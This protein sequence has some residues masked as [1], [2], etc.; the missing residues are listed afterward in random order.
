MRYIDALTWSRVSGCR[1]K[2]LSYLAV[3][4]CL[5]GLAFAIL[6]FTLN[7]GAVVNRVG[8]L[9]GLLHAWWTFCLVFVY[10][11]PDMS[12]A[13]LFDRLSYV[14]VLGLNPALAWFFLR[15][16]GVSNRAT[17]AVVVTAS[18][19]AALVAYGYLTGG[20][21][22]AAFAPGPWGNVGIPASDQTWATVSD[23]AFLGLDA[24]SFGILVQ[25]S[26]KAGSWRQKRLIHIVLAGMGFAVAAYLVLDAL[27]RAW[28]MPSLIFLPS[29]LLVAFNFYAI[30]EYRF[31]MPEHPWLEG[32]LAEAMNR[33][34]LLLDKAGLIVGVNLA[35]RQRLAPTQNPVG[36]GIAS[37]AT[38]PEAFPGLWSTIQGG[39]PGAEGHLET[40]YGRFHLSGHYDRFGDFVGVVALSAD[41]PGVSDELKGLSDREAEVLKLLVTGVG[42]QA[43]ADRLFVSPGTVKS[44][45]HSIL[46]KTGVRKRQDL[47]QRFGRMF[48]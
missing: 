37:W 45:V 6:V 28:A 34:A 21:P 25:K 7:P 18:A 42:N 4:A 8:A 32:H 30:Y 14:A 44:H 5:E 9:V 31:L 26:L 27:T 13:L 15:F 29:T 2:L 46:A 20:F 43:I 11:S 17:G 38:D 39:K 33:P 16:A 1:L 48:G 12:A 24:I 47:V 10:G 41:S 22:R 36:E 19:V 3:V 35:A 23:T 40:R